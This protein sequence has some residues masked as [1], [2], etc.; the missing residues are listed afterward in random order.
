MIFQ[1][2][3]DNFVRLFYFNTHNVYMTGLDPTYFQLGDPERWGVWDRIVRGEVPNPSGVI[4]STFGT[5]YVFSDRMHEA[6]Q[7]QAERDPNMNLVYQDQYSLV[8]KIGQ[9]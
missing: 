7:R 4:Q 1:T 2:D 8:W 3:W 9:S 5:D 6:F